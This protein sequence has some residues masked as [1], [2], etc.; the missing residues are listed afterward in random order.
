MMLSLFL[1]VISLAAAAAGQSC[2]ATP[3]LPPTLSV[4]ARASLS[5][6]P[7]LCIPKPF[8]SFWGLFYLSRLGKNFG[9]L[10][11]HADGAV[12]SGLGL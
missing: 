9:G 11:G 7:S 1:Y 4:L 2:S 5:L 8:P 12:H 10:P 3:C 6:S